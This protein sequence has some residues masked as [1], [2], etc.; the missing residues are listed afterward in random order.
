M[1]YKIE[2]TETFQKVVEIEADSYE[3]AFR[4]VWN[5]Y[6]DGNIVLAADDYKGFDIAEYKELL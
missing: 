6:L 4:K 1:K 2:I 5:D 3:K